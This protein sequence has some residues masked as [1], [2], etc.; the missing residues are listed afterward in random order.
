MAESGAASLK[1]RCLLVVEDEYLLAADLTASLESLGVEVVGPA[2]SVEEALSLVENK[3]GRLDGAVLDINLRNERV[4]PV[5]DVLTARGVPFVFTTGYDATAIPTAYACAPRCE[6]P[7]DK[8]QL[9][10]WLSNTG[11]GK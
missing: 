11:S 7:V 6:K 5:A 1:G 9:V 10:R 8:A 2:A 4:Y 3:G